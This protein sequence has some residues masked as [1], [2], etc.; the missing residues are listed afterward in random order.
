M[1]YPR[2]EFPNWDEDHPPEGYRVLP[3]PPSEGRRKRQRQSRADYEDEDFVWV[4][5]DEDHFEIKPHAGKG[6]KA[7]KQKQINFTKF[8]DIL[9]S[10]AARYLLKGILP[11]AGLVVV[12]GPPKCGKSFYV[13]DMVAHVAAGWPYRDRRVKQ[14]PVIYFALEGQLGFEARVEAF[15][16]GYSISDIPFY[17]STDRIVLPQDGEAVVASIKKQFPTVHPGIIVLDTLNR[18]MAG[19]EN[20][21]SDM[22][23]YVRSADLIR[24][25]FNCLVVVIHHCGIEKGRPRGHT[26]LTGAADGQIAVQ[27]DANGNVVA[28][29]EYMKDGPQGDQIVSFLEQ[30]TVGTDEDGDPITSCVIRSTEIAASSKAKVSG[31][32]ALALRILQDTIAESD[33]E[34]PQDVRTRTKS[35]TC[36]EKK[37]RANCYAGMASGDSNQTSRQ[38]A[39]VR[40]ATKLQQLNL[41]G[42]WGDFVWLA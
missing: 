21:P 10:T 4:E 3:I 34:P 41:I 19:S 15:R 30:V 29:V 36:L 32:A 13:F 16:K 38:K 27:R 17:L 37:W 26:S 35:R 28:L 18:S 25:T 22:A 11:S 12:W 42:K 23:A 20:D 6:S 14:C 31:Q 40:A 39:F 24:A 9:L 8:S 7:S 5:I 1:T 2:D 33:E